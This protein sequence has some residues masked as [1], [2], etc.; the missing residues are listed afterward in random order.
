MAADVDEKLEAMEQRLNQLEQ[1]LDATTDELVEARETV[2]E[3]Q[4]VIE[5]A[6]LAEEQADKSGISEFLEKTEFNG[7]ASASYTYNFYGDN[8]DGIRGQNAGATGGFLPFHQDSNRFALNQLWFA[9]NK[10]VDEESRAGFHADLLFGQDAEVLGG[11]GGSLFRFDSSGGNDGIEVFTGYVSY[12]IPYA[13]VQIDAGEYATLL[14]G[15]VVQAPNNFNIT[16]GILWSLQPVTHTGVLGTY[17]FD[18]GL[19]MKLGFVNDGFTDINRDSDNDKGITWQIAYADE[20]FSAALSGI[21][22]SPAFSPADGYRPDETDRQNMIDILLSANVSENLAWW[23]NFDW[24]SRRDTDEGDADSFTEND[25]YGVAIAGRLG[26]TDALG[27]AFRVEY[28]L[29]DDGYFGI[30]N[31]DGESSLWSFTATTDYALTDHLKVRG[32]GRMDI[33]NVDGAKGDNFFIS[34]NNKLTKGK[35]YVA[36][37]EVIYSF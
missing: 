21:H 4:Q 17:K 34:S 24:G 10:G 20:T 12:L 35:Q 6:G 23:I 5:R 29:E 13:E 2:E 3:Q 16:R 7:W 11:S 33:A 19:G 37:A 31:S 22:G 28:A 15:E 18:N 36:L 27:Q 32:E 1:R 26:I 25:Y 9:M 14:G 8:N 30:A